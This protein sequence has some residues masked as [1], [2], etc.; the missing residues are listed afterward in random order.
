MDRLRSLYSQVTAAI[1]EAEAVGNPSSPPARAAFAT[2]SSL[3]EEI[4]RLLPPS[5]PEGAVARRGAIRAALKSGNHPR[6]QELLDL[7]STDADAAL[8]SDMR[9]LFVT[10]VVFDTN[11]WLGMTRGDRDCVNAVNLLRHGLAAQPPHFQLVVNRELISELTEAVRRR[12]GFR[13]GMRL[14]DLVLQLA[15]VRESKPVVIPEEGSLRTLSSADLGL[16][17]LAVFGGVQV[18]VTS[19]R[20]LRTAATYESLR[21]VSPAEFVR[22]FGVDL[23][24]GR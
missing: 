21:L 17:D 3:E 8:A 1:A 5:D 24:F 14:L 7:F 16:L 23:E 15:V 18:V 22:M 6:A 20:L 4:A 11:V 19:D 13:E 9:A 12:R 2:V 10:Q